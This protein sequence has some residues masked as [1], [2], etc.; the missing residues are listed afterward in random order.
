MRN[1]IKSINAENYSLI[2]IA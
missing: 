2:S 1:W